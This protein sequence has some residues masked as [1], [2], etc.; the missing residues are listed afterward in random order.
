MSFFDTLRQKAPFLDKL[1]DTFTPT[2]TRDEKFR[3]KYKLPA[4]ENIL[5]DT[6]AEV[7]FATPNGNGKEHSDMNNKGRKTAYVFSGRLFLTPHFLVFRDAFDHSSCVL[8]L[9]ISTIKRVER[10]PSE[11]YEFALLVTLYSG[12]KVLIQFIGIRYRSEQFCNKLKSNL[13]QNIPNAKALTA[14]LETSYSE[15]LIAKNIQGKKDITVPRAGLG[16]H[17]KYPGSPTMA[18]EK[19]KLRLWFDYFRQN[20]R[21]LAVVQTPMF[22][23]LIRIGVPNR[24]RGEIWEL[25]SGAMYLRY[26]NVGEYEKILNDNAGK[27]SQAMM[28]SKRI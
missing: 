11:S 25:C 10:S 27:T 17:F 6:N 5:D 28:K 8:I 18:K 20:G 1:A 23:K 3:L 13:K 9:N 4:N 14:F 21:N 12:A 7:S 26:A 15:F 24:M 22:R 2:L 19:A 16:Q